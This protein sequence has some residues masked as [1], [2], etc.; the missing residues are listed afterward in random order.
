MQTKCLPVRNSTQ[1]RLQSDF[2]LFMSNAAAFM[3]EWREGKKKKKNLYTER[4]EACQ[5]EC[6]SPGEVRLLR[7]DMVR[8]GGCQSKDLYRAVAAAETDIGRHRMHDKSQWTG[9]TR[10]KKQENTEL[11]LG[12]YL[13]GSIFQ[14]QPGQKQ[15]FQTRR[16]RGK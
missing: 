1:Q 10:L 7:G 11:G 8:G 5:G 14:L 12:R 2:V 13:S 6:A 3:S 16:V 9:G 15:T 4:V